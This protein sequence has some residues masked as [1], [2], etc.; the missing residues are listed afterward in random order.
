MH[1]VQKST[2]KR[3]LNDERKLPD[4]SSIPGVIND[5]FLNSTTKENC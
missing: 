1:L 3:G 2:K 5:G 4:L